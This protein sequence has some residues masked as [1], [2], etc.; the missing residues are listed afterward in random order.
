MKAIIDNDQLK[1]LRIQAEKV[2]KLMLKIAGTDLRIV[3]QVAFL[4]GMIKA[5]K[6]TAK[7]YEQ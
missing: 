5:T 7:K 4:V 2:D 3:A 6:Y 1:R